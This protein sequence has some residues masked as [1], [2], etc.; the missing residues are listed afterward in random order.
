MENSEI[1]GSGLSPFSVPSLTSPVLSTDLL[2]LYGALTDGKK[3]LFRKMYTY[4]WR[5]LLPLENYSIMQNYW[6]LHQVLTVSYPLAPCKLALLS[7]LY[8]VSAKGKLIIDSRCTRGMMPVVM[9]KRNYERYYSELRKSGYITRFTRDPS[10][11]YL[12]RSVSR[13]PIF[14][15]VTD[16][17]C[18]LIEDIERDT[19]NL[20]MRS[21]MREI[22]T[23]KP[24]RKRKTKP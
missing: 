19:Y 7:W 12:L 4:L 17:G 6:A 24:K 14:I 9:A 1:T 18:K 15:K 16:Q 23:G 13:Q 2:A 11:P 21:V 5:Y 22:T 3:R 8:Q 20:I 10:A